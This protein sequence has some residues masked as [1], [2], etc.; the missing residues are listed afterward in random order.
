MVLVR[1]DDALVKHPSQVAVL[2]FVDDEVLP[3]HVLRG[4]A[5]H[6]HLFPFI[7]RT[8]GVLAE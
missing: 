7:S 6:K 4:S 2:S 1:E 3:L 5:L 8:E